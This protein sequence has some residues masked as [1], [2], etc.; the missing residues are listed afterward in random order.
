MA[1]N[2]SRVCLNRHLC[3]FYFIGPMP[4]HASALLGTSYQMLA[5]NFT[6]NVV[7]ILGVFFNPLIRNIFISLITAILLKQSH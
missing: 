1:C 3:I 2:Y 6:I 4:I 5:F 7:L